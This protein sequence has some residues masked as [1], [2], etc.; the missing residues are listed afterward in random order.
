LTSVATKGFLKAPQREAGL[1]VPVLIGSKNGAFIFESDSAPRAADAR[2]HLRVEQSMRAA[3]G[4]T[5]H[6][7]GKTSLAI[8][9]R[10]LRRRC[11]SA[12]YQDLMRSESAKMN[13]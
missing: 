13:L 9:R 2:A 7:P 11:E 4:Q 12:E 5:F 8:H 3:L 6:I 1:N 10:Q